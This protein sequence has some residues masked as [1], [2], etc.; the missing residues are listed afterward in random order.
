MTAQLAIVGHGKMGTEPR[1]QSAFQA[2]C[3]SKTK[4][5]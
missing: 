4:W 1:L 3:K 2:L 5:A